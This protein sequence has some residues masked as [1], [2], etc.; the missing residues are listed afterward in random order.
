MPFATSEDLDG[1]ELINRDV[2]SRIHQEDIQ[3]NIFWK[4]IKFKFSNMFSYGEDN[5]IDFTKLGGLMG[6]LDVAVFWQEYQNTIEYMF[7]IWHELTDVQSLGK[8][9]GFMFLNTGE[10]RVTGIDASFVGG[11]KVTKKSEKLTAKNC[12]VINVWQGAFP[13]LEF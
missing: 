12:R 8:S 11:A 6:Y 13:F 2:N 10:S 4:P 3:R 7:G 9:A 1:L 5:K